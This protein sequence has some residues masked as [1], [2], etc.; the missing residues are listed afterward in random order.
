MVDL[1]ELILLSLLLDDF[2]EDCDDVG[3]NN[4]DIEEGL[5]ELDEKNAGV[6]DDEK[7]GVLSVGELVCTRLRAA[8]CHC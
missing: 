6:A 4:D 3:L 8:S 7:V 1:G 2:E 5:E